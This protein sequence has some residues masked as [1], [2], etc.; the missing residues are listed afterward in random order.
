MKGP[1]GRLRHR[2]RRQWRCLICGRERHTSGAVVTLRCDHCAV[3]EPPRETWMLLVEPV[4]AVV[5][6]LPA[7][8][9]VSDAEP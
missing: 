4:V 3:L 1:S 8:Q 6:V 5:A 9:S 7:E 2:V